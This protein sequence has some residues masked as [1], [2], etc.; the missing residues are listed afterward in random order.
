MF[1]PNRIG[2]PYIH[3]GTSNNSTSAFT[4]NV[5]GLTS[6]SWKGNVIS[7]TPLLDFGRQALTWNAAAVSLPAGNRC[8][9]LSQFTITE[10]LN[11]DTVGVEMA[12]ALIINVNDNLAIRPIFGK[13][14]AAGGATL[15]QVDFA[16]FPTRFGETQTAP[17]GASGA[18][19][20]RFAQYRDIMI[21]QYPTGSVGGTYAHGFEILNQSAAASNIAALQMSAS[22]RQLNDQQTIGYRDTRK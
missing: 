3:Q 6:N 7:S 2:T 1:R 21:L 4:L 15:A 5:L 12:G 10:P 20:H 18:S 8:S 13:L 11:G 19:S 16:D 17:V 9:F 22:V 14:V